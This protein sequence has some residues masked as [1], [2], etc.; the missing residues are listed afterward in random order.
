MFCFVFINQETKNTEK[1]WQFAEAHW[2]CER[3]GIV[4]AT[5]VH[6]EDAENDEAEGTCR[7]G[8]IIS[9]TRF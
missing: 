5:D 4:S 9:K 7:C 1:F 6:C 3:C 2:Y 8:Q